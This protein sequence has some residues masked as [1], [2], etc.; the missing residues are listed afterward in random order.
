V[1][2]AFIMQ[3]AALFTSLNILA[4]FFAAQKVD[5]RIL[6]VRLERFVILVSFIFAL[7]VV[8]FAKPMS[9]VLQLEDYR[10][11]YL[12]SVVFILNIPCATWLGSLQGNGQFLA[13]GI[14]SVIS[15]FA[16]IL[17]AVVAIAIGMGAYGA[18]L[19]VL[20]GTAAILP[21]SYAVQKNK[22]IT[23]GK[24]FARVRRSDFLLF[25]DEPQLMVIFFSLFMLA[26]TST[27]D[28]IFSK[29]TLN[30]S[31][32]GVYAQLS[33]AGK[34]PYFAAVP[35]T[36]ILF[37]R[38]IR[39]SK[40]TLKPTLLFAGFVII[41]T[42]VTVL[43]QQIVVGGFFG[44]HQYSHETFNIICI[45]FSLYSFTTLLVYRLLSTKAIVRAATICTAS[46]ATALIL[47]TLHGTNAK[48][49]AVSFATSQ[50]ITTLLAVALQYTKAHE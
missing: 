34:I 30:P 39:Q 46:F 3:A 31:A 17:V 37:E 16:K 45:A 32:A 10:L 7:I 21:L 48:A 9:G 19:G 26:L 15:S 12:L 11:L 20:V 13:S 24:T 28:V 35:L 29:E 40:F 2:V 18:L 5:Q 8:I 36:I 1:G 14:I 6:T 49:I 33:T 22:I 44:N 38:F 50:L 47:I 4:L 27:L 23:F 41:A 43:A 42:G 25:R